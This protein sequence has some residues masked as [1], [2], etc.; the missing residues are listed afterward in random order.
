MKKLLYFVGSE[1][2]A[3]QPSIVGAGSSKID[4]V[5]NEQKRTVSSDWEFGEV[6]TYAE[7]GDPYS[8]SASDDHAEQLINS[9]HSDQLF[10]L[11][12]ERRGW[13]SSSG[14]AVRNNMAASMYCA[15][16]TEKLCKLQK[17]QNYDCVIFAAAPH[18]A[19]TYL[20]Y[21]YFC[22]LGVD[23]FWVAD[24]PVDGL[25]CLVKGILRPEIVDMKQPTAYWHKAMVERKRGRYRDAIPAYMT[26]HPSM[27]KSLV[28]VANN[29]LQAYLKNRMSA[30]RAVSNLRRI[31]EINSV[32]QSHNNVVSPTVHEPYIYF[33]L[34]Y[35]PE[36]NTL[37]R[38]GLYCQQFHAIRHLAEA[39]K[40]NGLHVVVKEHP[41]MFSYPWVFG[42]QRSTQFYEFIDKIDNVTLVSPTEDSFSLIDNADIVSTIT[43]TAGIEALIRKKPVVL[44]GGGLYW[45]FPGVFS[46]HGAAECI[47]AIAGAKKFYFDEDLLQEALVRC[48]GKSMLIRDDKENVGLKL[49]G[50]LFMLKNVS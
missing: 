19:L 36:A 41:A 45:D 5:L 50:Q 22:D 7:F 1:I 28:Q 4:L 2:P 32:I 21:K 14:P 8:S 12:S 11:L 38:G 44:L 6:F 34:H 24:S 25:K 9:M 23:V 37:P 39:A 40:K 13:A 27:A 48:E 49:I 29:I 17:N 35:Q 10:W 16:A 31:R 3:C 46:A 30:L 20:V 42:S 26:R 33:G 43:G 15:V 47:R 18:Q